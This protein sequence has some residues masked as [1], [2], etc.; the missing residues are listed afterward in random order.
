MRQAW[1]DLTGRLPGSAVE[2]GGAALRPVLPEPGDRAVDE[3]RIDAFQHLVAEA[4]PF[5]DAGAEILPHD[6]GRL[7]EALDDLDRLR[8]SQ[9]DKLLRPFQLQWRGIDA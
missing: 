8:L 6:I 4:E 2:R 3:A 1:L 7:G 9:V 5:H